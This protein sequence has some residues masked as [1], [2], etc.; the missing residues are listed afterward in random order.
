[1]VQSEMK[2]RPV[3]RGPPRYQHTECRYEAG[4]RLRN[5]CDLGRRACQ[6]IQESTTAC[7]SSHIERIQVAAR[8][9]DLVDLDLGHVHNL[10]RWVAKCSLGV[11]TCGRDPL[12]H[13][14]LC[15]I[16]RSVNYN[17]H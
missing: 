3:E 15:G 5:Q 2:C 10:V 4:G 11:T 1:M 14:A 9:A 6:F 13:G 8:N 7:V 12:I 16:G 17:A